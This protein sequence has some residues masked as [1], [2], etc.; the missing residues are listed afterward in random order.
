MGS[1]DGQQVCRV[2]YHCSNEGWSEVNITHL[3]ASRWRPGKPRQKQQQR[4]A[5]WSRFAASCKQPRRRRR[6]GTPPAEPPSRPPVLQLLPKLRCCPHP[7]SVAREP[8]SSSVLN[9][10]A[11]RPS[12][13]VKMLH[14]WLAIWQRQQVLVVLPRSCRASP[15]QLHA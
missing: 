9:A 7:S 8:K 12:F 6:K 14:D 2:A 11:L 15:S 4:S 3:Y 10:C 13:C 1:G 5:S